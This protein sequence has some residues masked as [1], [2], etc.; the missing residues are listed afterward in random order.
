MIII[1]KKRDVLFSF[2]PK[3]EKF[4]III[5]PFWVWRAQPSEE[6]GIGR[7]EIRH[8]APPWSLAWALPHANTTNLVP[9][10]NLWLLSPYLVVFMFP[11]SD[12][13]PIYTCDHT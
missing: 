4:K 12:T 6:T 10:L 5:P 9:R 7:Q 1:K 13:R 8:T 2:F 11:P 3:R